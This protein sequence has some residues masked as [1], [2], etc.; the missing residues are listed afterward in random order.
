MIQRLQSLLLFFGSIFL[1]L[2]VY[3]FPVLQ[4]EKSTYFLT[5]YFPVIRFLLLASSGLSIFTIFQFKNTQRQLLLVG[6][7]RLLITISFLLLVFIY[8]EDES[9]GLGSFLL[10]IPYLSL[11]ASSFF[12]KKDQRLIKSADRIR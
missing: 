10:L 1:F 6:F 11:L 8:R 3:F 4:T 12:I 5:E 7:S 9:F 2:I